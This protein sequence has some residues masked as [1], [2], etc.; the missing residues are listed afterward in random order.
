[1]LVHGMANLDFQFS[2]LIT[3]SF[4]GL[5]IENQKY[6]YDKISSHTLINDSVMDM[7]KSKYG[8]MCLNF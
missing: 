4:I 3:A 5:K 7:Q 2:T 1:M 8:K 6:I